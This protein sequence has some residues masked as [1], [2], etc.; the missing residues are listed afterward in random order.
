M[1]KKLV[2]KGADFY[3]NRI[4]APDPETDAQKFQR[5]IDNLEYLVNLN[6]STGGTPTQKTYFG[7][8]A[9]SNSRRAVALKNTKVLREEIYNSVAGSGGSTEV[10]PL[11]DI[12]TFLPI[13]AG[14]KTV[15]FGFTDVNY[16]IGGILV[17]ATNNKISDS[18]WIAGG[19]SHTIDVSAYNQTLW[20]ALNSKKN[21]GVFTNS[22]TL[23]SLGFH[24]EFTY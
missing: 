4:S 11:N 16:S 19:N 5:Y 21:T 17:S 20:L 9:Q 18:G 12:Y 10:S 13:P 8:P 23:Q 24:I 1:G 14:I 15:T 6:V 2:I 22:E 7:T 3:T